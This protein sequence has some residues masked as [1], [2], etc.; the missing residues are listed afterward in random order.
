MALSTVS[1]G[2]CQMRS[3][4]GF[5]L[6]ELMIVLVIVA[7][8]MAVAVPAYLEHAQKARR[9]DGMGAL[10]DAANR[11]EQLMLDRSTY[12]GDMTELGFAADPM[13]SPEGHYQIDGV[14]CAGGAITA[15]SNCYVLTATPIASSPQSDDTRCAS[16]TLSSTG[17]R[18]ASGT[19]GDECW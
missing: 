9:S 12:S 13:V 11:E 5:T 18:G 3:V 2:A 7:I 4:R 8:L 14:D 6:I 16:L 17:Q 10:M 1:K 19:T 15:A